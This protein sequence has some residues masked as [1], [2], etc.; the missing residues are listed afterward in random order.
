MQ[1]FIHI[2]VMKREI[3]GILDAA[4]GGYFVDCT[5]GLG[6]HGE[7]ILKSNPSCRLLGIDRDASA[8]SI[9]EQR[10]SPYGSRA[11]VVY[12]NFKNIDE[13]SPSLEEA[14]KGILV[15]L[16]L[17]S[18]QLQHGRGFS[19]KDEQSLDMRMDASGGIRAADIISK[20]SEEELAKIF[21]DYGEVERAYHIA[22]AIAAKRSE[23]EIGNARELS[24][25]INEAVPAHPGKPQKT[26]PATRVFQALRI[27][28]N[29]ELDGLDE[30]LRKAVSLLATSGKIVVIS[31]HS[32]EDRIVKTVFRE[33]EKGC[34]CPP[35][36]PVCGCGRAGLL[37]LPERRALRPKMDEV[38][39]N[40]SSRSAKLRW[41]VRI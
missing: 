35:K 19:F 36:L 38:L 11:A 40:P 15:D 41:A 4:G 2:P 22:K 32:L 33:L 30:F 26:N 10:L 1:E 23:K 13:W 25:I 18:L 9:A 16:G 5:L 21:K 31:Y 17:S 8:L 7:E 29:R 3:V 6:G 14:P 37:K 24:E 20:A 34:I 12:N 39:E 27:A 28:V